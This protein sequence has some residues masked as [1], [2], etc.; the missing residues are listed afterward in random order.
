MV[1][2]RIWTGTI[3]DE[4][5][6]QKLEDVLGVYD[7]NN[8]IY[9]FSINAS[10]AVAILKLDALIEVF[11][12]HRTFLRRNFYVRGTRTICPITPPP[13]PP[14]TVSNIPLA[15]K[16]IISKNKFL[17]IRGLH[18]YYR[19]RTLNSSGIRCAKI[20]VNTSWWDEDFFSCPLVG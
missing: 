15:Q 8:M 16:I 12:R 4:I 14:A 5:T 13:P 20:S 2:H 11:C 6:H 18:S 17:S 9:R 7:D 19:Q 3:Y 1:M 10:V